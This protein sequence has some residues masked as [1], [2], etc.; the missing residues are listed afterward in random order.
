LHNFRTE[1]G[2]DFALK[3][4]GHGQN[5]ALAVLMCR[6]RS[7]AD[8]NGAL[9]WYSFSSSSSLLLSSLKFSDPIMY[10][11]DTKVYAP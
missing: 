7:T 8:R 6:M 4:A 10:Q 2:N 5:L 3:T 1:K 11:P 9:F